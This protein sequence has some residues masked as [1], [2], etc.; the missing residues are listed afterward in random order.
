MLSE[1]N[2][3]PKYQEIFSWYSQKQ[4]I[5]NMIYYYKYLWMGIS[6]NCKFSFLVIFILAIFTSVFGYVY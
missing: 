6:F 5:R 4:I 1:I 2:K 3:R